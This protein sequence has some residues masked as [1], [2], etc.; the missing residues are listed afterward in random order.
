LSL[1]ARWLTTA[2]ISARFAADDGAW[3]PGV[4]VSKITQYV[5]EVVAS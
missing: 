3:V 1:E 4:T 5:V 2:E